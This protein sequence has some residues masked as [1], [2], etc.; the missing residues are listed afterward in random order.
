MT[1]TEP[2]RKTSENANFPWGN[3]QVC[4]F[5]AGQG[6]PV[7][8]HYVKDRKLG[9]LR[10]AK[11]EITIYAVW[12]G[13]YRSDLFVV[14]DLEPLARAWKAPLDATLSMR[15]PCP[16]PPSTR[17]WCWTKRPDR[18]YP[19]VR[20]RH[21]PCRSRW[22]ARAIL[23]RRAGESG[24]EFA[25]VAFRQLRH[26]PALLQAEPKQRVAHDAA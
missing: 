23:H 24:G 7:Q 3:K 1:T 5:A 17:L 12:P 9:L 13:Q 25:E 11:G 4:Y 21:P 16:V 15:G 22:P 6:E 19:P 2:A 20:E 26:Q 10:A 18:S 8:L 14:D